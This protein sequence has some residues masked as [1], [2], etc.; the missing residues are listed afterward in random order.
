VQELAKAYKGAHGAGRVF[1]ADGVDFKP[2]NLTNRD[3]EY[4]DLQKDMEIRI[5]QRYD[6]PLPLLNEK[7][8]TYNNLATAQFAFYHDAVLPHADVLLE[9]FNSWL[10]PKY[11]GSEN[12]KL[13]YD[14]SDIPALRLRNFEEAK[15]LSTIHVNTDNELRTTL[16]WGTREDGDNVYKP[17]NQAPQTLVDNPQRWRGTL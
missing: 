1:A 10:M 7:S 11:K 16:G 9:A 12:L 13:T 17:I 5:N 14:A 4:R 8:T 6:I 2:M 15:I 3:M